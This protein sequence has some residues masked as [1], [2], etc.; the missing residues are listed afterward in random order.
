MPGAQSPGSGLPA[1]EGGGVG[2]AAAQPSVYQPPHRPGACVPGAHCRRGTRAARPGLDGGGGVTTDKAKAPGGPR[3]QGRQEQRGGERGWL[4]PA[5][6]Q[7]SLGGAPAPLGT[8]CPFSVPHPPAILSS[9]EVMSFGSPWV[10]TLALQIPQEG[11]R[12]PR[13]DTFASLSRQPGRELLA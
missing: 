8:L 5:G 9:A 7:C 2:P 3:P 6:W 10:R 4:A 1:G 12:M 13:K 11:P